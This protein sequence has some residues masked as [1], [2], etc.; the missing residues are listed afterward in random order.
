VRASEISSFTDFT[1]SEGCTTSTIGEIIAIVI[2]ARSL[3]GSTLVSRN[4]C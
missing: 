1:G 3:R 2:G 4:S